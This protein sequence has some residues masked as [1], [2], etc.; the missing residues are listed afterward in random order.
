[1]DLQGR[2]PDR[3]DAQPRA[4]RHRRR[5][6]RTPTA[7]GRAWSLAIAFIAFGIWS[8][9]PDET[10]ETAATGRWGPLLTTVVVFFLAEMGDKT[11]LARWRSA[12]ASG[13]WPR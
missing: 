7:A 12:P 10:P 2:N 4:H 5:L 9:V 11:Q 13:R 6:D 1:V 8:L 3:D